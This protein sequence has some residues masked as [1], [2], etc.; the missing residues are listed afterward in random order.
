MAREKIM[1]VAEVIK[2]LRW[3]LRLSQQALADKIGCTQ[4]SVSAWEIASRQPNN[5]KRNKIRQ[6][7]KENNIH[8][9]L[10]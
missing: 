9:I 4:T 1:T 3:E 7:A 8:V 5:V 6:L 10:I 2:L